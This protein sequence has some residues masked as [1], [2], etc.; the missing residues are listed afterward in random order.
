MTQLFELF[1]RIRRLFGTAPPASRQVT[2][3]LARYRQPDTP[4]NRHL[5]ARAAPQFVERVERDEARN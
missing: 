2:A 5:M 1:N 4:A 3:L